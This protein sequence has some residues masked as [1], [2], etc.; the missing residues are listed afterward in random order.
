MTD[1]NYAVVACFSVAG[2]VLD[3][4]VP[5][6][7]KIIAEDYFCKPGF[8]K[9]FIDRHGTWQDKCTP[10]QSILNILRTLP[11]RRQAQIF[12]NVPG[13][14]Q[15]LGISGT[16]SRQKPFVDE[17]FFLALLQEE[18]VRIKLLKDET[19]LDAHIDTH[20]DYIV[21]LIASLPEKYD[22]EIGATPYFQKLASLKQFPVTEA[23]AMREESRA[24]SK[25]KAA[26]ALSITAP[27][28]PEPSPAT[29]RGSRQVSAADTPVDNPSPT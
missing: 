15:I 1:F 21:Q 27:A 24:L 23:K 13:I 18:A 4:R 3:P 19:N 7:A 26:A 29:H 16:S 9:E 5:S 22:E 6:D 20:R 14:L 8:L 11:E 25:G 12:G 17:V 28:T 10:V 2:G